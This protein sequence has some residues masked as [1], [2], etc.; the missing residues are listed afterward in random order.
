QRQF[1]TLGQSPSFEMPAHLQKHGV[2]RK[3]A[4]ISFTRPCSTCGRLELVTRFIPSCSTNRVLSPAS[5]RSW[6]TVVSLIGRLD[7]CLVLNGIVATWT[8]GPL[9]TPETRVI[10][11][12]Y[13]S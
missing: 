11:C 13:P 2:I 9:R 12:L 4:A 6:C 10:R 1:S 3:W 8:I 5:I 7:S